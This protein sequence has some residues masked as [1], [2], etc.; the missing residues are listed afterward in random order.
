MFFLI[1][2]IFYLLFFIFK[3]YSLVD[4]YFIF[5]SNG[6]KLRKYISK[7]DQQSI[8]CSY[9]M[10]NVK[11]IY[12][13][14]LS[15]LKSPKRYE[16]IFK[17]ILVSVVIVAIYIAFTYKFIFS[18][19]LY[20]TFLGKNI[21]LNNI[22]GK[23]IIFIQLI[24]IALLLFFI[25]SIVIHFYNLI[26]NVNKKNIKLSASD[27]LGFKIKIGGTFNDREITLCEA[28]LYQNVLITGSIGSGKTSSA[29]TNILDGLI[30]EGICG[31]IIDVKGNYYKTIQ[32]VVSKY[33]CEDKIKLISM[34]SNELYNPIDKKDITPYELSS[35]IRKALELISPS[36]KNSDS[37]WLDK[38]QEYVR[39]FIT[40]MRS[41]REFV[42]F[43]EIY[44][45]T[46]D[47]SYLNEIISKIKDD[48]LRGRYSDETLFEIGNAIKIILNEYL[49]LDDRTK[50]IIKSEITRITSPFI[51][52]IDVN[53]KFCSKTLE[54]MFCDGKITILSMNIGENRALAKVIATYLKL[55]FQSMVL[56][57]IRDRPMFFICDE[58]QEFANKDDANFFSLSREYKCINVVSMQS[59]SSL[60][61]TLQDEN[62]TRVIIQNLVNKVWFRND[63]TYTISEIIKYL[64][65]ENR[66]YKTLSVAEGGQ[67]TKYSFLSSKFKNIKSSL[68]ESYSISE[69]DEYIL[70]EE[71]FSRKL[72]TFEAAMLLSDGEKIEF[73]KKVNLKRW[74]EENEKC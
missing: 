54:N 49:K 46:I 50:G 28:G 17:I 69:K 37:F 5:S 10:H 59:Y 6:D 61:N 71:Y 13:K 20:F 7:K 72:N 33:Q 15:F 74:E 64:G 48:I 65:K 51:A 66:K 52:S 58:Y 32:K 14:M 55:D 19:F 62:A 27:S 45:L 4:K 8:V 23:N 40:I 18:N 11:K 31:L 44:K 57:K 73:L 3:L 47:E 24:Y 16:N 9:D 2:F 60:Q 35:R 42:S 70:N 39:C 67:N 34:N 36:S 30:K 21:S 43:D 29:I 41:Y 26:S 1:T 22:L 38:V 63:D 12:S 56:S 25:V 68:T 53:K